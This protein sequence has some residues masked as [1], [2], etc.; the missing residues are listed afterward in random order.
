[1]SNIGKRAGFLLMFAL[2]AILLLQSGI[3]RAKV[4]RGRWEKNTKWSYDTRTRTVTIACKGRMADY[5]G[6]GCEAADWQEWYMKA[7]RVVFKKGITYIGSNTFDNFRA[8]EEVVLPEGLVSIGNS[9]F[10]DA[11]KLKSI[12][13]PST[14]KKIGNWTFDGS[15]LE[16]VSLKNVEKIGCEAFVGTNITNVTIPASCKSI[17]RYAFWACRKL[18]QVRIENGIQSISKGM[19]AVTGL[20]SVSIPPS[21]TEIG[22]SAFWGA[23]PKESKLK[24]FTIN[25]TKITKWGKEIFGKPRKDLVIR[26]PKSKKTEYTKA[27]REGGLPAYV[28]IVA[29]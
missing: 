4:Y 10:W 13:F 28:K 19:F 6:D 15:G 1:M 29:K 3:A 26:V 9:A 22:E 16:S 25:S 5:V 2:A 14:L 21:V 18:K 24:R 12:R 23:S 27:L 7:K 20:E 17:R 8:V 11:E